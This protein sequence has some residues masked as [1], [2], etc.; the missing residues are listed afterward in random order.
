MK[1]KNI[2]AVALVIFSASAMA[3]PGE[4]RKSDPGYGDGGTAQPRQIDA[5]VN[6]NT[7]VTIPYKNGAH[8]EPCVGGNS[9][10]GKPLP[11]QKFKAPFR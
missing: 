11:E 8:V 9:Y 2:L 5:C 1:I 7:S 3:A 10:K 6:A 4:G